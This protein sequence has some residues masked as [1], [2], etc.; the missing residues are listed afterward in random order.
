MNKIDA[1][2]AFCLVC[3]HKNFSHV[4]RHMQ[5]STTMIS[6]YIKQLEQHLGCLLLKRDTRRVM[7]TEAG[8]LYLRQVQPILTRLDNIDLEMSRYNETPKGKLRISA[9][10]E[11]GSQYLAPLITGFQQ[12]YPEVELECH[13]TNEPV[14]LVDGDTDIALRVAPQLAD[15]SYIARPLCQ[16]RLALWANP[17]YLLRHGQ[18]TSLDE[19]KRHKLLFFC[20]NLRP[21][22]WLFQHGGKQ[23]QLKLPWSWKSNNGRLLNEA[24]ALCQGII[25]APTY[26]VAS[27]V[28][29]G[30]LV[31]VLPQYSI[32]DIQI[33]AVYQHRYELS[34]RIKSFVQWSQEYFKRHPVP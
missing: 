27:Y 5:L 22:S 11:F 16:T 33:S 13:L 18:P 23:Q 29:K 10:I 34:L 28:D 30:E 25:Q 3:E 1:M 4:A 32:G 21:D 12:D 26:S 7:I 31:E 19:L 2:K 24:A 17:E 6:R 15:A 20:H 14:A 8:E 9:S